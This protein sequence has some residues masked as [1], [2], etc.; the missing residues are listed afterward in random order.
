M[1][2]NQTYSLIALDIDGTMIGEDRLVRPELIEAIERVQNA[3]VVVSVSTGR[4]LKPAL[5]I[6]KEVGA[7]GPVICFQGAMTYDQV[8]KKAIRHERLDHDVTSKAITALM[9]VVPEVM[10]FLGDD[11]WVE[12]RSEWTNAYGERMGIAI[13]NIDSLISMADKKPTAIVGVGDPSIVEPLVDK[14]HSQLNGSALVTHSLPMFCEVE[15]IGAGK[16][17]AVEHLAKL[18]NVD[19]SGVITVGDGKGDQSM[20]EWA[21]LG[22]AIEGGHPDAV[23]SADQV[24]AIPE[25]SGLV[26]FLNDLLNTGKF[27]PPN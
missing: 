17:L 4:T 16:D 14:L 10:M 23:R 24:I 27:G 8:T 11:V 3:G 13:R 9:S 25:H 7:A 5:R 2:Y 15:A 21:G 6:A 20:I 19:R 26:N 18:L 22:V 12:Q 1:V